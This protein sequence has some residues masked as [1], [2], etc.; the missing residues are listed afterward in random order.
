MRFQ[1]ASPSMD[2]DTQ[3]VALGWHA[4]ALSAPEDVE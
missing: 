3:G 1:G 4:P 2:S